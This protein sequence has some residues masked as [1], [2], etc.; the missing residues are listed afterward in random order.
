MPVLDVTTNKRARHRHRKKHK[1]VIGSTSFRWWHVLAAIGLGGVGLLVAI[2]LLGH[3][4]P[5]P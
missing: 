1:P 5:V 4:P 2:L 3:K